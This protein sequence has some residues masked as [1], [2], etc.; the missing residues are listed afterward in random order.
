MLV[1]KELDEIMDVLRGADGFKN[2]KAF[3][4]E[5]SNRARGGDFTADK[6]LDTVRRF[7]KLIVIANKT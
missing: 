6:I 5:G 1:Q 7:H 3:L 4:Q 2:L